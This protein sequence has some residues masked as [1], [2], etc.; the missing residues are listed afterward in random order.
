MYNDAFRQQNPPAQ[1]GMSAYNRATARNL[2]EARIRAQQTKSTYADMFNQQRTGNYRLSMA[3]APQ[4]YT[5]GMRDQ[6]QGAITAAQ[7]GAANRLGVQ[8]ERALRDIDLNRIAMDRQAMQEAYQAEDRAR[9]TNMYNLQVQQQIQ[10]IE[11]ND[12]LTDEQKAAQINA[13]TGGAPGAAGTLGTATDQGFFG[14]VASGEASPFSAAVRVGGA[15]GGAALVKSAAGSPVAKILADPLARKSFLSL[16]KGTPFK[17]A[18]SGSMKIYSAGTSTA[19]KSLVLSQKGLAL[20]G[21]T[22]KLGKLAGLAG[23]A[24]AFLFTNPIGWA[25]LAAA[26]A[27]TGIYAWNKYKQSQSQEAAP[28]QTNYASMVTG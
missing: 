1:V 9:Q 27:G 19:G 5:G 13:I 21:K 17:T 10:A 25:V 14:Q 2:E 28:A 4:G 24:G 23:K 26:A 8:Q 7:M 12:D 15:L 11:A 16:M 22:F 18:I 3:G 6:Y 20:G